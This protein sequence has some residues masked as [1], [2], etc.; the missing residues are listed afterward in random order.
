MQT[1]LIGQAGDAQAGQAARDAHR[2]E[3]DVGRALEARLGVPGGA[4][5]PPEDDAATAHRFSRSSW[6]SRGRETFFDGKVFDPADPAAY[7]ASLTI[8]KLAGA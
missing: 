2:V 8:K 1:H 4:A 7:L 3:R 6:T 5:V